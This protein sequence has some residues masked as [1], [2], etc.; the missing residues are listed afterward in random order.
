MLELRGRVV[1][2]R[3]GEILPDEEDGPPSAI[4][5][6][7]RLL[8]QGRRST[9]VARYGLRGRRTRAAKGPLAVRAA[10]RA[11]HHG[12]DRSLAEGL[13]LEGAL[14]KELLRTDDAEEGLRAFAERRRRVYT[15]AAALAMK[16]KSG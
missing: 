8:K 6:G 11:V 10:K 5:R 4:S 12:L 9:D 2:H 13:A 1:Q 7:G 16:S 15:T 14:Q 3:R